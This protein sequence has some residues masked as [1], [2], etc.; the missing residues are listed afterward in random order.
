MAAT[1]S[2]PLHNAK[3]RGHADRAACAAVWVGGHSPSKARN[4]SSSV[5]TSGHIRGQNLVCDFEVVLAADRL[6]RVID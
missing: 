4:F 5:T 2:T 1:A 3:R 6:D